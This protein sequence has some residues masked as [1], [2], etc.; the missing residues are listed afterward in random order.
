MDAMQAYSDNVVDGGFVAMSDVDTTEAN[1]RVLDTRF[2]T[3]EF[4]ENQTIAMPYG[5]LGFADHREFGLAIPKGA[6]FGQFKVFQSLTDGDLSFIV[7]PLPVDSGLIDHAD[8]E[9]AAGSLGVPMEDLAILLITTIRQQPTGTM[10]TVNTQAPLFLDVN[11][12]MGWQFVLHNPK[13][14]VQ[15]QL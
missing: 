10:L 5:L 14:S 3:F 13:Y 11:R 15:Q 6:E 4:S 8:I 2:G 12:R 7:L 9:E 1:K